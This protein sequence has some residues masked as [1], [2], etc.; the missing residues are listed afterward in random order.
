MTLLEAGVALLVMA[1]AIVAVVELAKTSGNFRRARQQRDVA[2]LELGNQAERIALMSWDEATPDALKSWAPSEMLRS[3]ITEPICR[4][5]VHATS[6]E[7]PGR[8]I[9]LSIAWKNAA[10]EEVQPVTLTSW[11]FHRPSDAQP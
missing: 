6:E 3:V 5:H 8:Q 9:E 1:A 7:L 4:V 2:L 10:G 11:K